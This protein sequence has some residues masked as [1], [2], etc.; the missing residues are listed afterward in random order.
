MR[1]LLVE[2]ERKL[3]ALIKRAFIEVHYAVDLADNSVDALFLAESNPYDLI[4]LDIM[5]P[6][7][8]GIA[9]CRQ[10]RKGKIDAPVLMLTARNDVEDKVLG[11]DAGADDYLTKPFSFPEL[12]ARVRALLRRKKSDK[13]TRLKV[14]D[15]ELDQAIR[16]AYRAGKEIDL[17]S[18]EYSLL[19]YLMLNAGQVVTRTMISEHVWDDDFDAYSNVIN[20]YINYLRK[21][22]DSNQAQQLIHSLRGVGYTLKD[23]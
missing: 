19:E 17:T 18:T 8:D 1:I 7:K 13:S 23:K 4:I 9:V 6:G 2:D 21:K 16:K 3:A 5:I 10:L 14:A 15:L 20:V 22:I 12:L 11:L